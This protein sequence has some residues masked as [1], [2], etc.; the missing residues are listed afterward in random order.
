MKLRARRSRLL[1]DQNAQGS[2]IQDEA[3]DPANV[4]PH[5]PAKQRDAPPVW[6]ALREVVDSG[7]KELAIGTLRDAGDTLEDGIDDPAGEF[8]IR[9]LLR[10]YYWHL[11]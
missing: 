9:S 5:A 2:G 11:N 6:M 7:S 1:L 8:R 10:A 4:Q 3:L